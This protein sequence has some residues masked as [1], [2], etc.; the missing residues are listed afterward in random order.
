MQELDW[1]FDGT[2]RAGYEFSKLQGIGRKF[3]FYIEYH[4]GYSYEGQFSKER[5]HYMQYNLS[6]GF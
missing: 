4:H 2:Y 6:Y 1:N 5:T 3:R